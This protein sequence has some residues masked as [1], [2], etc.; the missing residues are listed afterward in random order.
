[1]FNKHEYINNYIK[2]NYKSYKLRI[3]NDDRVVLY[4]LNEVKNINQYLRSLIIKDT[5]E[6]RKYSFINNEI[7][8]DFEVSKTIKNLMEEAEIADLVNDYGYYMNL[9]DAIDTE[10]KNETKR[11]KLTDSQWKKLASRYCL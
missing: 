1:M 8:I 3:R 6:N 2:S 5:F 4:K 11:H 7:Q 9:A 10:A